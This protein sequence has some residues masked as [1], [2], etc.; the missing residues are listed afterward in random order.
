MKRI[1]LV[2][3]F[4]ICTIIV[5]VSYYVHTILINGNCVTYT[6]NEKVHIQGKEWNI[7]RVDTRESRE[8]G[9]SHACSFDKK[10]GM[11]FKF[12]E[13]GTYG[14]W[15]KDMDFALDIIWLDENLKVIDKIE[16]LSPNTYPNVYYPKSEALYVLE[17]MAGEFS[18]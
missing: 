5:I 6:F 4:I 13:K 12:E 16:N 17:V 14:F 8:Q 11:L 7:K 2:I 1:T 9:L 15:M 18:K 3:F 10:E